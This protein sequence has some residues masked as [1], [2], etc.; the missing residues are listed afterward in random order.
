MQRLPT[1]L[2]LLLATSLLT[3]LSGCAAMPQLQPPAI[4][5]QQVTLLQLGF[6]QQRFG[7]DV[8]ISNPNAVPLP[9]SGW[10]YALEV[11]GIE[12]GNGRSEGGLRVPANGQRQVRLELDVN[13]VRLLGQLS[14]WTRRPPSDLAY[15]FDSEIDVELWPRA[16][17]I[18]REGRVPLQIDAEAFR[19]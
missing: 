11:N 9:V 6:D 1:P 13:A 14:E 18:S 12:L 7:L 8:E 16:L 15:R 10:R 3:L 5:L 19:L 4:S 2:A 17:T